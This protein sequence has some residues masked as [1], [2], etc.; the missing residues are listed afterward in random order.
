MFKIGTLIEF[1]K[2][3]QGECEIN[4]GDRAVYLG[5]SQAKVLNGPSAN[6]I[7]VL[8]INA[9]ITADVEE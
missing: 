3:L 6:R 5:D 8:T 4:A 1:T 9:P 7:V 2:C